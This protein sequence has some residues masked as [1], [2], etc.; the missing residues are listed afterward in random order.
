M[1]PQRERFRER[2]AHAA[3]AES[4]M[5]AM[6]PKLVVKSPR[7]N[8]TG[9]FPL[10]AVVLMVALAGFIVTVVPGLV[11]VWCAA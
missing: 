9:G 1:H 8:D 5:P 4:R 7:P 2:Q 11:R 10:A 6:R 3:L